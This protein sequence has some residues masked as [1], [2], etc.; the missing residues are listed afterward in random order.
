MLAHSNACASSAHCDA[1]V[2][3]VF[4]RCAVCFTLE[5]RPRISRCGQQYKLVA[6]TDKAMTTRHSLVVLSNHCIPTTPSVSYVHAHATNVQP[7][8]PQLIHLQKESKTQSHDCARPPDKVLVLLDCGLPEALGGG[9][10][11]EVLD[12]VEAV[13]DK[14]KGEGHLEAALDDDGQ[15]GEGGGDAGGL[16]VPA[17]ERGDEVADRVGVERAREEHAREALPDGGAEEGLVLVVDLE[18]RRHRP[19]QPLLGQDR[20]AVRWRQGLRG[21]GADLEGRREGRG[22]EEGRGLYCCWEAIVG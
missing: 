16:E 18:V 14:G 6:I 17:S 21:G 3:L 19:L 22:C 7:T 15:G 5:L 13:E 2:V 9:V 20:L 10:M 12:A 11:D 1:S 8:P 4:G